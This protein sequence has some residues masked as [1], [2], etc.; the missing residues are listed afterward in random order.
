MKKSEWEELYALH[1][2]G[3]TTWKAE[4]AKSKVGNGSSLSGRFN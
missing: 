2:T 4:L 3:L 1:K